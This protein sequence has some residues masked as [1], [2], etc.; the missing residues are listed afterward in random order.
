MK[1]KHIKEFEDGDLLG[2]LNSLGVTD[3]QGW[4]ITISYLDGGDVVTSMCVAISANTWNDLIPELVVFGFDEDYLEEDMNSL[5]DWSSVIDAL[6]GY[7]EIET[8]T[9][10][11]NIWKMTPKRR[12]E[13]KCLEA[14]LVYPYDC[15]KIGREMFSDFDGKIQTTPDY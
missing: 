7:F 5:K 8:D 13:T 15:V 1:L 9:L 6:I 3:Y 11:C 2:D 14:S 10:E 12:G 4:Y